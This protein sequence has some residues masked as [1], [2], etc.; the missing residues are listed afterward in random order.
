[1]RVQLPVLILFA[2]KWRAVP[3]HRVGEGAL[4]EVV[5]TT[6][7][8]FQRQRQIAALASVKSVIRKTW[9]LGSSSVS[10]GQA[11]Q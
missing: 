1:M 4:E 5:I 3:A 8:L 11:A 10:N 9:A 2:I 7:Q 6:G